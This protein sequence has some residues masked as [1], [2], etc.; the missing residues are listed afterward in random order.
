[1]ITCTDRK[2]KARSHLS[3]K[4]RFEGLFLVSFANVID[5][6]ICVF[7]NTLANTL[8]ALTVTFALG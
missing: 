8:V 3:F 4:L 6:P 2:V 5:R 7:T 1:M